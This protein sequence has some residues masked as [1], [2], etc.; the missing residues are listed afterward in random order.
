MKGMIANGLI[1]N[2]LYVFVLP[3]VFKV[4]SSEPTFLFQNNYRGPLKSTLASD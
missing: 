4:E 3:F 2:D 1:D